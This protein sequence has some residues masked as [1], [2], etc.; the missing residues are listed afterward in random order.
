MSRNDMSR[1]SQQPATDIRRSKFGRPAD[2]ATTMN[3]GLLVPFYVDEGVLPSDTYDMP[4]SALCRSLSPLKHPVIDNA[5]LD[6]YYFAVPWRLVWEHS[7]E[8]HGATDKAWNADAANSTGSVDI[9]EYFIPQTTVP[10][11][12]YKIGSV[13]DYFS[14]PVYT[15]SSDKLNVLPY[16]AYQKVWNDFFRDGNLMDEVKINIGDDGDDDAESMAGAPYPVC[17][18]HDLFTSG[19]PYPQR[20]DPVMLG[21]FDTDTVPVVTIGGQNQYYKDLASGGQRLRFRHT[22]RDFELSGNTPFHDIG[23][24]VYS[25]AQNSEKSLYAKRAS[26]AEIVDPT[27]LSGIFPVNLVADIHNASAF[28][29]NDLRLAMQMQAILEAD[30]RGGTRY[31]SLIRQH[32]GVISPDGR[33]QRAEYLGG[34]RIALNTQQVVQQSGVFADDGDALGQ[35]GAMSKTVERL[36]GCVKSFTE[37]TILIGVMC[38]RVDQSYQQGLAKMWKKRSRFDYYLPELAHIGE[39]PVKNYEI[40]WQGPGV[41]DTSTGEIVDDQ[42]FAFQEPWYEYRFRFNQKTGYLRTNA[43]QLMV[44]DGEDVDGNPLAGSLDSWHYGAWYNRLPML[45][46]DWIVEDPRVIDRTLSVSSDI[47]HQFLIELY[48]DEVDTRPMPLYSIPGFG[49]HF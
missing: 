26:D 38:I 29:I 47:V 14:I 15:G 5:Y 3:A 17:K 44:P 19:L 23:I 41:V 25:N 10:V 42:T 1:I 31:T 11:G 20:G 28:S 4:T 33:L 32:F 22:G 2:Y 18:F 16:R 27:D 39:M 12:G 43:S 30:A 21:I 7:E 45:N 48:V 37:H 24:T 6:I 35:V 34:K 8:F 46:K 13:A 36:R 49:G 40:Y 9:E